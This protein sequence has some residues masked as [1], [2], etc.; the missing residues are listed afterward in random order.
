MAVLLRRLRSFIFNGLNEHSRQSHDAITEKHRPKKWRKIMTV[1]IEDFEFLFNIHGDQTYTG[2]EGLYV[3]AHNADA[4]NIKNYVVID[5]I[6]IRKM[7]ETT[8]HYDVWDTANFDEEEFEE[9]CAEEEQR[10]AEAST[11]HLT[12]VH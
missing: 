1:K 5:T 8:S 2:P 12:V 10:E 6:T 4:K 3:L 7:D 11:P 9:F